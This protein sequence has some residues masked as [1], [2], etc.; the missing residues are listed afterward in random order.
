MSCKSRQTLAIFLIGLAPAI[1][2][3]PGSRPARGDVAADATACVP[4]AEGDLA[5]CS[6]G[7]DN[8]CDDLAD[9]R[10]PNCS[11]IG[12]CPACGMVEHTLPEP[13]PLPDGISDGVPCTTSS[14]CDATTPSCVNASCH[15]AY[16][17]TLSFAG[18]APNEALARVTNIQRVCVNIEHSWFAD[19]E[20][21]LRA[22]DGKQVE[23]ARMPG[24]DVIPET[25]L[26]E[27][28]DCDTPAWPVPG[29]GADYCWTPSAANPSMISYVKAGRPMQWT[30][31][32]TN[33][34]MHAELPPGDYGIDGSWADLIGA[35]L[36]GDWSIVVTDAWKL[37]NGYLFS[38]SIAF[39]PGLVQGCSGPV[40]Q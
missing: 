21:V 5:T 10:D 13:L 1:A 20:V 8:D 18:F 27:A 19:L 7:L 35:P 23:L 6:D 38:W 30:W 4:Q 24:R 9:C 39:D 16:T 22:P 36:N 33:D 12:G 2:C 28:N 17:S 37:D 11:G 25:Y 15:S 32:C 34:G 3:G 29:V 14:T 26:G 31:G 40:I